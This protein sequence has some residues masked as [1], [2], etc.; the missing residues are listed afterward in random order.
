MS[1]DLGG[2][3]FSIMRKRGPRHMRTRLDASL[4]FIVAFTILGSL[5]LKASA[6]TR[7]TSS[8]IDDSR[9][10]V[11]RTIHVMES[12]S[13]YVGTPEKVAISSSSDWISWVDRETATQKG[14]LLDAKT[15]QIARTFGPSYNLAD[16]LAERLDG[17]VFN[18]QLVP[19]MLLR[20]NPN[21]PKRFEGFRALV[22][23][24]TYYS[25]SSRLSPKWIQ[26]KV[27]DI[28]SDSSGTYVF[29]ITGCVAAD[30]AYTFPLLP[31]V[32]PFV[33][34]V[35]RDVR[36]ETYYPLSV[37]RKDIVLRK[38][39]AAVVGLQPEVVAYSGNGVCRCTDQ[40]RFLVPV[41]APQE[42]GGE[43]GKP[44]KRLAVLHGEVDPVTMDVQPGL[45]YPVAPR[46]GDVERYYLSVIPCVSKNHG[47]R[48]VINGLPWVYDRNGRA[49][50]ELDTQGLSFLPV[51]LQDSVTT[52]VFR[53]YGQTRTSTVIELSENAA[54]ETLVI[55]RVNSPNFVGKSD[56]LVQRYGASGTLLRSHRFA[57]TSTSEYACATYHAPGDTVF[58]VSFRNDTWIIEEV[59]L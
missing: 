44:N 4:A 42:V 50:F 16:S 10:D 1:G 20:F 25:D 35:L 39:K 47:Y 38:D 9:L 22:P 6:I 3:V 12:D 14:Y 46:M 43:W 55:L 27:G 48:Y 49:L 19:E 52:S 23:S 34:E 15:G 28:F 56:I 18:G 33:M 8:V 40:R 7:C 30:S 17:S 32:R 37:Y 13:V 36:Q 53:R 21:L 26:S 31:F 41:D 29:G 51:A 2:V 24:S 59:R 45:Y 58:V 54:G 57:T 11:R 5:P